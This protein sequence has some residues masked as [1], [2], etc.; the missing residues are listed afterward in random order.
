MKY[1]FV[2]VGAGY[3]GCV[4]A[5]RITANSDKKVLIIEQ[6]NHIGGNAYDYYDEYGVLV[7]KY[8]PHIFHTNSKNVW[9]YLSQFTDWNNYIHKVKAVIEGKSVPVPFNFNSINML[10]PSEYAK[11]IENILIE[12]F[13]YGIK[14]PILKLMKTENKELKNLA[15]YIYK[16]VFLGYT[17]K[18]WGMKPEELDFS[19]SSRVPVYLSRDDRYF[20]DVYQG[21]LHADILRCSKK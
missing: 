15:E 18:Q 12:N 1:D 19:V 5:E 9:D 13:G 3:S 8:G 11:R 16:Y 20:Q 10:F 14:I 4:L 21:C 7:H 17:S 6:R 2:I